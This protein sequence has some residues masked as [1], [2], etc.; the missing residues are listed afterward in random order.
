LRALAQDCLLTKRIPGFRPGLPEHQTHDYVR[1]GIT[2]LYAALDVASGQVIGSRSDRHR[3]QECI[4]SL[5]LVNRNT[6][7]GKVLDL[8]VDNASSHDTQSVREYLGKHSRRFASHF[9][10]MHASWLNLVQPWFAEITT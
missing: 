2:N 10:P 7:K 9:T 1:H 8:I 6:P 4:D 5:K 3:T